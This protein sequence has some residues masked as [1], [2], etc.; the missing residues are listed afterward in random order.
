MFADPER[1]WVISEKGAAPVPRIY[2][3]LAKQKKLVR[4][5]SEQRKRKKRMGKEGKRRTGLARIVVEV[6]AGQVTKRLEWDDLD[7]EGED[8]DAEGGE[9]MWEGRR[10]KDMKVVVE[11]L[12]R[13][14]AM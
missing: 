13:M 8:G 9:R 14:K 6:A 12:R 5:L 7:V 4:Q 3:A 2:Y 1:H 10:N 11:Q